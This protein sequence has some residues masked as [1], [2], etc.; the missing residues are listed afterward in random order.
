MGYS[1]KKSGPEIILR[2]RY[3]RYEWWQSLQIIDYIAYGKRRYISN[4]YVKDL[5]YESALRK[6][7]QAEMN[8]SKEREKN[9]GKD[10]HPRG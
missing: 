1:R 5:S 9:N 8:R 10:I 4:Y 7:M 2:T 6:A 3:G